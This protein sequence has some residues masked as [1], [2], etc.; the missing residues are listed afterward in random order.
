MTLTARV[1]RWLWT[2]LLWFRL[3]AIVLFLAD[4]R[5]EL[6]FWLT[7]VDSQRLHPIAWAAMAETALLLGLTWR[8]RKPPPD[9]AAALDAAALCLVTI[10]NAHQSGRPDLHIWEDWTFEYAHL[11]TVGLG[12]MTRRLWVLLVCVLTWSATHAGVML[13]LGLGFPA[14]DGVAW[15]VNALGVWA[16]IAL[17]KDW[18]LRADASREREL[19]SARAAAE[20]DQR[21]AFARIV[22]DHPLRTMERLVDEEHIADPA[23]RARAA[24]AVARMRE[25]VESGGPIDLRTGLRAAAAANR[26]QGVRIVVDV[27][28]LGPLP[29]RTATAV[30]GAVGELL[31]NVIK[32]ADATTATVRVHDEDGVLTVR[33]S[34]DGI[35]YTPGKD[36]FGLTESVRGRIEALGGGVRIENR[37]G[38]V[39]TLT[40]SSR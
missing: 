22:Y 8:T 29:E 38:A 36:G 24:V 1:D 14:Y 6:G 3:G 28:Q 20:A 27:G 9:W 13:W 25:F 4:K 34:D 18:A 32:H 12:L 5:G 39:V 2:V 30:A 37:E 35:G 15:L 40:V 7:E 23:V 10:A 19:A 31:Q 17:V 33:V 21:L 16:I 11:V 26:N